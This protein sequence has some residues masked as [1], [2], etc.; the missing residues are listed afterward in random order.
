MPLPCIAY[1]R[2]RHYIVVYEATSSKV[3]VADSGA[4]TYYVFT[5]GFFERLDS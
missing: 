5:T 1:W 2:Q 3:I 4:W